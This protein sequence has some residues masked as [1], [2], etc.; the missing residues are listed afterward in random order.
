MLIPKISCRYEKIFGR[1]S[2][3]NLCVTNAMREDLAE[4]WG[5]RYA[6]PGMPIS[7]CVLRAIA[8]FCSTVLKYSGPGRWLLVL[9]SQE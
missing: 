9:R 5:V 6:G 4:N 8:Q 2:H 1:L 3:L 7:P